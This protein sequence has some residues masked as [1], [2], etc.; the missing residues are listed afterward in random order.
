[1]AC[2]YG[3]VNTDGSGLTGRDDQA[4]AD[5]DRAIE[6]APDPAEDEFAAARAEVCQLTGGSDTD[7]ALPGNRGTKAT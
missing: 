2:D 5:L 6:L 7:D 3:G 1:L 4:L